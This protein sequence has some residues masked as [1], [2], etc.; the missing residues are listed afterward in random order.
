MTFDLSA[1]K[2]IFSRVL[3]TLSLTV[4]LVGSLS[5]GWGLTIQPSVAAPAPTLADPEIMPDPEQAYEEARQIA[6]DPKMGAEKAYE[7]EVEVF[8]EEH[9]DES[10]IEKSKQVA[11]S[12]KPK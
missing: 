12:V 10:L 8:R 9:P 6:K 2:Q 11:D 3:L 7:K 4:L 5:L 1:L